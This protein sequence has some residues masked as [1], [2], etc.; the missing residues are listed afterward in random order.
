MRDYIGNRGYTI[1]KDGLSDDTINKIKNDLSV[2]PFVPKVMKQQPK[3]F[4]IYRESTSKF[5]LP[6]FYGVNTFCKDAKNV[7]VK[8]ESCEPNLTFEGELREYQKTIVDK[9]VDN[10][11][12]IGGGLLEIDTG[13][14][15]TVMALNILTKLNVKTI[16]IVHKEF[17]MNQWIERI[18]EFIPDAK[19]GKIQG[20]KLDM[21]SNQ[22]VIAMLQTLCSKD[23]PPDMFQCFGLTIIDEVHHMGA[24]V[25]SQAFGKVVTKYTLGLSATMNR[26][27]GLSNVFKMFL[28][29]VVHTEKRDISAMDVL[30][31]VIDYSNE[32]EGYNKVRYDMRGNVQYSTMI[33]K[34]CSFEPRSEF[35]INMIITLLKYDTNEQIMVLAHNKNLLKFIYDA[36]D[37]RQI[38]SVGYYVGGMKECDLKVSETKKIVIATYSMASEGLDI[39][40]LTTLILATPKTDVV[41]SVG[42]ILRQKHRQPLV[43]DIVDSHDLFKRQ[44]LKRRKFYTQQNY[45]ITKATHVDALNDNFQLLLDRK[46]TKKKKQ[47]ILYKEDSVFSGNC[48]V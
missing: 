22:I 30:V 35:I 21:G 2:K 32:D 40:T 47:E 19:V 28:G 1:H 42:R 25:F 12:S 36:I 43:V 37:E 13:M 29:D 20:K 15:K 3:P 48:L 9:Y 24:E 38:A 7:L 34:L 6:K 16:I 31:K 44:F 39:K 46:T 33:T 45:T 41:Q 17:L 8:Y 18:Q 10:A 26:K 14:G 23:Y 27:D 5:Y 4:P 11:K